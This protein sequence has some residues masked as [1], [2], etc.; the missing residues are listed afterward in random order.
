MFC[1][2]D[3]KISSGKR[4]LSLSVPQCPLLSLD[5][6]RCRLSIIYL[7]YYK[8]WVI[9]YFSKYSPT[10]RKGKMFFLPSYLDLPAQVNQNFCQYG[11]FPAKTKR[12]AYCKN[13]ASAASLL[14]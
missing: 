3:A 9:V 6:L 5:V 8:E 14:E 2:H 11:L 7:I 10:I 12:L 1:D 13:A 4:R